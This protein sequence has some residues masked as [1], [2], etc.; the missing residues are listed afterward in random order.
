METNGKRNYPWLVILLAAGSLIVLTCGV[1]AT[2]GI[3]A[4][5]WLTQRSATTSEVELLQAESNIGPRDALL[6]PTRGLVEIQDQAGGWTV[7]TAERPISEGW[8]VRTGALSGAQLTFYD[9]SRATLWPNTQMAIEELDFQDGRQMVVLTQ[10]TG[11]SDHQ[12]VSSPENKTRYEVH[13]LAG[14]AEAKGTSFHVTITPDQAAHFTVEEGILAVTGQGESI[15]LEAGQTSAIYSDQPHTEPALR[16]SGEGVVTQTGATW[17]IDGQSYGIH[18]H[19]IIIG[20]PRVGDIVHVEG[21]LLADDTRLADLIV[22]LR[23]SPANRFTLIGAV[24]EIDKQAWTIAGQTI[25]IG[26]NTDIDPSIKVGDQVRVE[27]VI[28]ENGAL[29]AEKILPDGDDDGLPF[30][31]T[32]V[33]ETIGTGSWTISGIVVVIDDATAT[34]D[35]LATGDLVRVSG[36]IQGDGDWLAR[37]ITRAIEGS[38]FFEISGHIESIDPWKVAGISFETRVWT[39]IEPGL[40]PGELV[41]VKG[42][43]EALPIEWRY[44][45]LAHE[46]G[47]R[48]ALAF[49]VEES[50]LAQFGDA[51]LTLV[52]SIEFVPPAP[53]GRL[54]TGSRPGD[55]SR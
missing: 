34:D 44:Y 36:M 53:D 40:E 12:V 16:I 18:E 14:S 10:N 46:S 29:L 13:T 24:E 4:F 8:R 43:V 37:R 52:R 5:F 49:T 11:E 33:V 15:V 47:R 38:R 48:V 1:A 7:L 31:F 54:E 50:L 28:L 27:G 39:D 42:Q 41:R 3:G 51:D 32:G 9:G 26:E 21:R 23:S 17:V 55:A 22:L 6:L 35:D 45:L 2:L 30:E 25:E 19:T 20:N